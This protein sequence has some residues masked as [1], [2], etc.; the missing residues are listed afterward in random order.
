MWWTGVVVLTAA[1]GASP[2]PTNGKCQDENPRLNRAGGEARPLRLI[3]RWFE[4]EGVTQDYVGY[5]A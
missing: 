2:A 5:W 3:R 4:M 1:G